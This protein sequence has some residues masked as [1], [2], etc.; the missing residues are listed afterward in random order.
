M[1]FK[2]AFD[3]IHR[4]SLF[5]ILAYYGIPQKLIAIISKFYEAFE[6]AVALDNNLLTDWFHIRSGVRQGDILSPILFLITIDWV[7]RKTT[8]DKRRGIQWGLFGQLEDLDFADDLGLLS[9]KHQD[10]QEKTERLAQFAQQVGLEINTK[11]TETMSFISCEHPPLLI[12]GEEIKKVEKFTYLGS[13]ISKGE[14]AGAD[15]A[16]RLA[17]ARTAF[18][19][20]YKVWRSNQISQSLKIRIYK[21][22]VLSV[23]LYG[24]E[25]W[26]V[27]TSEM[28]K[29][30]TFNNSCLRRIL[31]IFWPNVI[32]NQDL[33]ERTK[34]WPVSQE[35]K[36]RR[37]RW[38]GHALRMNSE[39]I[40]KVALRWTPPGK[41]KRG[42]P[43]TTWRRSVEEELRSMGLSWGQAQVLAKDRAKWRQAVDEALY[44]PG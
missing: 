14:G 13:V 19:M 41:R 40:P 7:M 8:E 37:L 32:S 16:S 20:L 11:K 26:R 24:A 29:L 6:C 39:R 4:E 23:L 12:R 38:L 33:H 42:R 18:N 28:K 22:N 36:K 25:C 31:K 17:K 27:L 44:P 35:I 15:I 21:S 10:L 5:R 9:S 3:S 30:D 34:T 43:K 1:D 2:K